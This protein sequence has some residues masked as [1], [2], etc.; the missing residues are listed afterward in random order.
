M[1][2]ANSSETRISY[3]AE[4]SFATTPA[5]PSFQN[6][7]VTGGGIR[8]T[9]NA[10]ASNELRADRN[11]AD[12]VMLGLGVTGSLPFELS[13]GTFDDFLAAALCGAW[14]T[15]IV[16]VG[17]TKQSF[18]IEETFELGTT[19]TF[20]RYIGVMVNTFSLD[21]SANQIITGSMD[22]MGSQAATDD[23]I[24]TGATYA[25]AN[26]EPIMTASQSF[27]N[28]DVNPSVSEPTI[29]R[30]SLTINNN[31][32]ARP[33]VGSL[34]SAEFGFGQCEV[35]GQFEAYF[36]NSDQLDAVLSHAS[37]V[38]D[39]TLGQDANK[40]YTFRLAKAF[41]GD[42]QIQ[43]GGNNDDVIA[44]IPFRG[45]YQSGDASSI[46]ITRAVA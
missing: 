41:L 1:A 18:T 15:N 11:T 38:L 36:E 24:I 28:L 2:F 42:P 7:R 34:Y 45:V 14:S 35:S 20:V 27:A 10:A 23:A 5:T 32:R 12:Y 19:D 25:A 33:V 21:I 30:I 4:S 39:F 40:H 29:R 9:K 17:T 8:P 44:T 16:K 13:Y 3:I 26:S 46:K 22:L 31:L 6:L 37:G 43:V